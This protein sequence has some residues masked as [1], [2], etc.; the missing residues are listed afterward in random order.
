FEV[1]NSYTPNSR[2][3][4][5]IGLLTVVDDTA[6]EQQT[7][8]VLTSMCVAFNSKTAMNRAPEEILMEILAIRQNMVT[9]AANEERE[10]CHGQCS[11]G[12]RVGQG[13]L[14]AA[15]AP[16]FLVDA[17]QDLVSSSISTRDAAPMVN[18]EETEVTT[19]QDSTIFDVRIAG[20]NTVIELAADGA[21]L[22]AAHT[23]IAEAKVQVEAGGKHPSQEV[24]QRSRQ[25]IDPTPTCQNELQKTMPN[26]KTH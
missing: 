13:G 17:T 26:E 8:E 7:K 15:Y 2:S 23:I 9:L 14:V 25:L 18:Q 24:R 19:S 3:Q 16:T 22:D 1:S 21:Q 10:Y 4:G 6:I 11:S 12:D 5:N 20:V